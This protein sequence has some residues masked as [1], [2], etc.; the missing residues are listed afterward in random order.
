MAR[1]FFLSPSRPLS[2]FFF[3]VCWQCWLLV[4]T[5]YQI[6]SLSAMRHA[7]SSFLV[8]KRALMFGNVFTQKKKKRE[9]N[10]GCSRELN[11]A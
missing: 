8:E 4:R 6:K 1:V 3:G 9:G 2:F 5:A 7:I 11:T 10:G